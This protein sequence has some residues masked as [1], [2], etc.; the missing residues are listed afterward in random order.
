MGFL[1][2]VCS[3][4]DKFGELKKSFMK[5]HNSTGHYELI[6]M[7]QVL[8]SDPKWHFD[9]M[10]ENDKAFYQGCGYTTAPFI[11]LKN[12]ICQVKIS[13]LHGNKAI[14]KIVRISSLIQEPVILLSGSTAD[15]DWICNDKCELENCED[16]AQCNGFTY[17]QYCHLEE[18]VNKPIIYVKPSRICD[19]SYHERRCCNSSENSEFEECEK[20]VMCGSSA[21]TCPPLKYRY[22]LRDGYLL[23]MTR[24]SPEMHMCEPPLDHTNCS[25]QTRVGVTCLINGYPSTVSKYRI[26]R[27]TPMCD[28]SVDT[29]CETIL[30]QCT[31]HKHQLCDGIDDCQNRIDEIGSICQSIT[32]ETCVRKGGSGLSSLP[33]PLKW[34]G[35]GIDDCRNGKD[36]NWPYFCGAEKTRRVVIGSQVCSNVYLCRTG[37]PRF[38]EYIQLCDGTDT[39]G[40]ENNVCKA[41]RGSKTVTKKVASSN[42][43]LQRYLSYCHRGLEQLVNLAGPCSSENFMFP[44]G[45][46]YGLTKPLITLPSAQSSCDAMF[47]EQYLYTSC[48]NKCINSSC[49]LRNVLLHD[50][51]PDY[52]TDRI[53]TI[54]DNEYL[55]FVFKSQ[56]KDDVYVNDIFLCDNS[57]KCVPYDQVCDLVDDCGD[58]SDELNCTNHFQCNSSGHYVPLTSKCDGKIDCLDLS[59]ECNNKCSKEILPGT[60]LKAI[61][62]TIGLSAVLA[63][64]IT[65]FG[66]T[67]SVTKCRTTVALT[68]KS[69]VIFIS[70]GDL[71]IGLYLLTVSM[72]D[73]FVYG[74]MYCPMQITWLASNRCDMIGVAS[75][76]GSQLSLFAM[77]I[78]SLIRAHGIWNSMSVPGGIGMKSLAKVIAVSISLLML[79]TAISISPILRGFEDFFIN[80]MHYDANMKLFV[81]LVDKETHL[82]IFGEYYGRLRRIVLSWDSIDSM[83]ANMF[84]HDV[85]QEDFTKTRLKVGFYGN[86]GV[87]LFKYFVRRTDPQHMFVWSILSINFLCFLVISVCYVIIAVLSMK[88]SRSV[89]STND[90][91]ARRRAN[92]MN[93]KISIIITTDFLCW[94]PFIVVCVLHYLEVLDATPWYSVFSMVILPINSII[95]PL[96]YNDIIVKCT[97]KVLT[98]ANTVVSSFIS[99]VQSSLSVSKISSDNLPQENIEMQEMDI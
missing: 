55:T 35:D 83:V 45:D 72:F 87:C 50:S 38:V 59:D 15:R 78:L 97:G 19:P 34:L 64:L 82:Q 25:D 3:T 56:G 57:Y 51:C 33:I 18:N 74:K 46:I 48:T 42:Q 5:C 10:C 49:P 43:G 71:L 14:G 8:Y 41:S 20:T 62:W 92:R 47:G 86:D 36:E 73:G 95:N 70:V 44:P 65:I 76:I 32:K 79:S 54:V 67:W 29:L 31:V 4:Y 28:D 58:G 69:L 96:L 22:P 24:C 99:S 40:N 94:V 63:N 66:N 1:K 89:S 91:Q 30:A 93:Q 90:D 81:G 16:E 6:G 60:T 98:R 84:S 7:T 23:N 39:C 2:T 53:R 21:S 75:T 61:S 11:S 9:R 37:E 26:C 27:E 77:T 80:G 17:G 52:Y 12:A 88:S 68:N 13:V 85:G